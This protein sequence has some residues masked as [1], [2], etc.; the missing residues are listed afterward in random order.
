MANNPEL[1]IVGVKVSEYRS[2]IPL[3]GWGKVESALRLYE[4][5]AAT[6]STAFDHDTKAYGDAYGEVGAAR[7]LF[8]NIR[9]RGSFVDNLLNEARLSVQNRGWWSR[10]FEYDGPGRFHKTL[11]EIETLPNTKDGYLLKLGAA[12]VGKKVEDDLA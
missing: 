11:V 4:S 8:G 3:Q 10:D 2:G 12:Y 6:S 5:G 9:G 7:F 1:D